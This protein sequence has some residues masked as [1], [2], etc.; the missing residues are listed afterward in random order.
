MTIQLLLYFQVR[1]CSII[2]LIGKASKSIAKLLS[3]ESSP[4]AK[5]LIRV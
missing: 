3:V 2:I 4:M 5:R 1:L